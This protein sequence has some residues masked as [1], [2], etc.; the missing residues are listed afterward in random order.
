[1]IMFDTKHIADG[2]CGVEYIPAIYVNIWRAIILFE[3][4]K[5][6]ENDGRQND[7]YPFDCFSI[8]KC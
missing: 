2:C 7:V 6:S 8:I 3:L 5:F 1:M 4:H